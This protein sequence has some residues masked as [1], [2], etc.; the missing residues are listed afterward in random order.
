MWMAEPSTYDF[1]AFFFKVFK[2][3]TNEKIKYSHVDDSEI[4]IGHV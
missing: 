1:F 4:N 3:K 2:L